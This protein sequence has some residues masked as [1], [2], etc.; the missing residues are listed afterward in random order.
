MHTHPAL[1]VWWYGPTLI[2]WLGGAHSDSRFRRGMGGTLD[3]W[4]DSQTSNVPF[5]AM[6]SGKQGSPSRAFAGLF[7][8]TKLLNA[9]CAVAMA[10]LFVLS[11]GR[12]R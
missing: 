7:E 11:R 6:V 2:A 8:E 1:K 5:A 9:G 12:V 3:P 4:Y 10:S